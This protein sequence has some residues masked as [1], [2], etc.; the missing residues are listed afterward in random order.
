MAL[1]LLHTPA[2]SLTDGQDECGK[3]TGHPARDRR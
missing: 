1:V 3:S 2:L